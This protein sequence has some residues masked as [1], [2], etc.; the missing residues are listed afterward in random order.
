MISSTT[1]RRRARIAS[2]V[3]LATLVTLAWA[4]PG[5]TSGGS[6]MPASATPYGYSLQDMTRA[7]APFTRGGNDPALYPPTPFQVLYINDY[8]VSLVDGGAVATGTNAFSVAA[9]VSFFVPLFNVNDAPPVLG[10]FP[11]T[12]AEAPFYFFDQSQYGGRDFEVIVDG[13][14]TPIGAQYLSGPVDVAGSPGS[15]IITLGAF[16]SPLS[17]GTHTVQIRGGVYGD[18]VDDTYGIAFIQEDFTY[19]INVY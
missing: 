11:T 15:H 18:L 1:S 5:W 9:G 10:V 2:A 13:A 17:L 7:V 8:D 3:G 19:I 6:V 12:A 4:A 14:K 16:L